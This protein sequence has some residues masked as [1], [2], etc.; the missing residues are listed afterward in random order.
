MIRYSGLGEIFII[1][2]FP[3]LADKVKAETDGYDEFLPHVVFGNIFGSLTAS[4]LRQDGFL[5]N[6]IL[7]RI[8]DM[9]EEMSEHGDIETKNLV[10]TTPLE[11]LWDDRTTY[12]N[13]L[14]LMGEHTKRLWESIGTYIAV[15]QK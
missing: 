3:E 13:A 5:K 9:Y 4:L 10:Q 15:P 6:D 11:P 2:R 12:A 7:G 14:K 1:K 8:F